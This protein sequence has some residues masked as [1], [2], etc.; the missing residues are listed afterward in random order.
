MIPLLFALSCLP[1]DG[2]KL[3]AK[4]FAVAMPEFAQLPADTEVGYSPLPGVIRSVRADELQR[5]AAKHGITLTDPAAVCFEWRMAPVDPARV[6]DAMRKSLPAEARLEVLEVSRGAVPAG[7]IEFPLSMLKSGLW[8][9]YIRYGANGRY[10][11]WARVR[12]SLTQTRVVAAV[13]LKTG[14]RISADQLRVEQVES[15]PEDG[16]VTRIEDAVG[17]APKRPFVAGSSLLARMLESATT[18]Q[19]GDTVRLRSIAGAAQV[20]IEVHAQGAGRVGDFIPVKNP[21]SGRVLRAR[22]EKAGEVTVVQ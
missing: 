19:K 16:F 2:P 13:A 4:H 3:L 5:I 11:V 1:V 21:A 10:D 18:V 7:E 6:T 17:F 8:R 12:A 14:E 22:V 15:T 20:T 9:G